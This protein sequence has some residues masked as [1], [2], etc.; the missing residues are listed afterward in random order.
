MYGTST[1]LPQRR[2]KCKRGS[3][4][5][6]HVDTQSKLDS[7]INAVQEELPRHLIS[8]HHMVF[9]HQASF[10]ARLTAVA[11][12]LR[13]GD[14]VVKRSRV[15][16]DGGDDTDCCVLVQQYWSAV[17]SKLPAAQLRGR[18]PRNRSR[19]CPSAPRRR[20]CR[21]AFMIANN[22]SKKGASGLG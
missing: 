10:E 16:A 19:S 3:S 6:H 1:G 2:P 15:V 12:R 9:R 14:R 20:R 4:S 5:P 11:A 17:S 21:V 18:S 22:G 8:D 7:F 13:T